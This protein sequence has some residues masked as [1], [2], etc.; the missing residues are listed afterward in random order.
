MVRFPDSRQLN[1]VFFS[2]HFPEN[3]T[4]FCVQLQ[5]YGVRVLGI[6]DAPYDSLNG[7]LKAALTE[8]YLVTDMED[9]DQILR[10]V[11]F[12]TGKYGKIDRFE[13][14]N[15][16]WLELEARIRTDFNIPGPSLEFTD[17]FTHKSRMKTF[18]R[19]AGVPAI[20]D[21]RSASP[22][23]AATFAAEV[24][25]P[26]VVKPDR[27]AGASSTYRAKDEVELRHLLSTH[28]GDFLVEEFVDGI[29]VTYDGLVDQDGTIL[30]ENS[31]RFELSV[32][33]VVNNDDN[34]HY[35][36]LPEVPDNVR[37]A[38]RAIIA[39]F[40]ARERFFHLELFER[41]GSGDL[42]ALEINM[43]PPGAWMTDA[44][45]YSHETNVYQRWAAMVT[46]N[47]QPPE[48]PGRHF[49]GYASRKNHIVYVHSHEDVVARFQSHIKFSRPIQEIFAR[50]MGDYAYLFVADAYEETQQIITYIQEK[51]PHKG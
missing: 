21:C 42:V 2:P 51:A 14:L 29:I 38:G 41:R 48:G 40:D 49:T 31:H 11:G 26:V 22:D 36:C 30:F 3:S 39:A 12:F 8:Y 47:P 18:F 17:D 10:A 34:L 7:Q 35:V 23:D 32:M 25:Y 9:Y 27:G 44:I 24:G 1:F 20:R 5:R 6:G 13:S 33:E 43:R 45:N 37:E 46:R 50:A 19:K 15:E 28:N 4:D 16:Y